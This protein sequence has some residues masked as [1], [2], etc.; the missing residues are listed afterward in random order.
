MATHPT[1]KMSQDEML[2]RHLIETGSITGMEAQT[3]YKTRCVT[4]N[5]KRLRNG[6]MRIH[7]EFKKDLAGQRYARYHCLDSKNCNRSILKEVS[8]V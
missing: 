5:I 7:T 2:S 8:D 4:S 3:I 6:G 1:P